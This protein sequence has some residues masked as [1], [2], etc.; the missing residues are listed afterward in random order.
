M[1]ALLIKRNGK[2]KAPRRAPAGRSAEGH[3]QAETAEKFGVT[4]QAVSLWETENG[5]DASKNSTCNPSVPLPESTPDLRIRIPKAEYD[6]IYDR[7]MDGDALEAIA[8]DYAVTPRRIGQVV[9]QMEARMVRDPE[10]S[11]DI[12]LPER[13][14]RANARWPVA[15]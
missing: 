15:G 10:P 9:E 2:W 3:S 6:E 13:Y 4:R 14:P 12:P 5:N 8:A 7:A 1:P 11:D